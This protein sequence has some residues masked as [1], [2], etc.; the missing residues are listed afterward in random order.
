MHKHISK[1]SKLLIVSD[2]AMRVNET[3]VI[4]A[5]EPVVREIE[6]FEHLFEQ[7]T[8]IGYDY[9]NDLNRKNMRSTVSKK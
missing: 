1:S 9:S 6:N 2:T 4:E 8:W 5:F 7:I 3:G